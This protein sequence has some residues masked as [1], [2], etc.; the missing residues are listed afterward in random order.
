MADP[1]PRWG[2]D[3]AGWAVLKEFSMSDT[4]QSGLYYHGTQ[5]D[6]RLGDHVLVKRRFRF[7]LKAVVCYIPG[8][9]TPHPELECEGV[10]KW[11]I[12]RADGLLRVIVYGPDSLDGQPNRT[13]E[14]VSGTE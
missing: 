13:I 6:V 7:P 10:Q 12:E 3:Q 9:S 1:F 2:G 14:F 4:P 8:L 5:T 11:A